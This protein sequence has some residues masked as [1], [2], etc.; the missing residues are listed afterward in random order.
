[1]SDLA[2]SPAPWKRDPQHPAFIMDAKGQ[3]V[4]LIMAGAGQSADA[5]GDFIIASRRLAEALQALGIHPFQM[6]DGTPAHGYCFCPQ[7]HPGVP[8]NEHTGEC[9]DA[10]RAL[11]KAGVELVTLSP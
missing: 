6:E 1:M 5:N 7:P 4:C 8:A 11:K 9:R 10:R 3:D 2:A